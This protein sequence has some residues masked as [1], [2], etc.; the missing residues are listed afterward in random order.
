MAAVAAPAPPLGKGFAQRA[1][2]PAM[3]RDLL[4]QGKSAVARDP[5]VPVVAR[6][7]FNLVPVVAGDLLAPL[8]FK[9]KPTRS[10]S[11]HSLRMVVHCTRTVLSHGGCISF[12]SP[13]VVICCS[14]TT[15]ITLP[16]NL[17]PMATW[18]QTL[19]VPKTRGSSTQQNVGAGSSRASSA[20]RVAPLAPFKDRADQSGRTPSAPRRRDASGAWAARSG[21]GLW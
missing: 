15:T 4:V 5:L 8:G 14:L 18:C 17:Q 6:D 19:N 20:S 21:S 13:C 12:S 2:R 11:L 16:H 1:R 3:A 9:G 7:P 10:E